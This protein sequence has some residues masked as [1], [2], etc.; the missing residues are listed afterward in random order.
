MK[1]HADFDEPLLD[2]GK[3]GTTVK[4]VGMSEVAGKPAYDLELTFKSGD[5]EHHL[6]DASTYLLAKRTATGKD[7]DG[8]VIDHVV[9]FG[10][11]KSVNGR[12]VNHSIEWTS[13]DGQTSK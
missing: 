3:R 13:A 1:D 10:D 9:R 6:I 12:M 4:L 11:Y 2:H 5:V 8:K 7:K